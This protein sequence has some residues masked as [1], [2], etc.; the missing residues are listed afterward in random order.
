MCSVLGAALIVCG[1]YMVLWGKKRET[2]TTTQPLPSPIYQSQV[3]DDK[4][5]HINITFSSCIAEDHIK[6]TPI[7]GREEHDAPIKG[8]E[9]KV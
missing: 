7:H 5:D 3:V 2:K 9:E 4:S 6:K 1:L 8:E